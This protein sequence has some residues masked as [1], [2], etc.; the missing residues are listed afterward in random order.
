MTNLLT[1]K[2]KFPNLSDFT[3]NLFIF[4]II[5]DPGN[6]LLHLKQITF[7]LA[8]IFNY[9]RFNYNTKH[10]LMLSGI[11]SMFFISTFLMIS[12]N[13][14]YDSGFTRTYM[15]TFLTLIIF[16]ID[17]KKLKIQN[18][19]IFSS[20]I[21]SLIT[22][23]LAFLI[24]NFPILFIPIQ[25]N[26]ILRTMFLLGDK[27]P[28]LFWN[29][30]MVFHVS[31]PLLIISYGLILYDLL[32]NKRISLIIIFIILFLGLFCTGTR[33]NIFS[34]TLITIIEYLDYIY[35][36]KRKMLKFVLIS[37]S[38]IIIGIAGTYLLLTMKTDSSNVKDG[39]LESYIEFF[40]ENI[41]NI[42][43]GTGPGSY[44][45]TKGF[46]GNATNTELSYLELIRMFGIFF[47]LIF[48][49]IYLSPYLYIKKIG[50][51]RNIVIGMSYL[52]YLF[53]A[54]TNPYLIGPTGFLVFWVT[55]VFLYQE[56]NKSK[57]IYVRRT[58]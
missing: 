10:V 28:F 50:H 4:N 58:S 51:N 33:A 3:L 56:N 39:H 23:V 52:A 46:G 13:I 12:R 17:F 53:I 43:I 18:I 25:G 5:L 34:L 27:K 44:F 54:G 9:K 30:I 37:L 21:I 6:G 8:L 14:F 11:Y 57:L 20:I 31:S 55:S 38:L 24:I 29:L 48:I 1:R 7:L 26:E 41:L 19:L 32:R 36:E 2:F 15:T 45:Y 47:A 22:I 35:F 40:N 42:I 16:L 49:Y